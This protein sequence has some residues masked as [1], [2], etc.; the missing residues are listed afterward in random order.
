MVKNYKKLAQKAEKYIKMIIAN[1]MGSPDLL[2]QYIIA[3]ANKSLVSFHAIVVLCKNKLNE[4]SFP[5]LRS[6]IENSINF[7]WILNKNTQ[8]RFSNYF[9]DL[10]KTGFGEKWTEID[11]YSRMSELGFPRTYYDFVVKYTY[12]HSHANAKS[13]FRLQD[14]EREPFSEDAIY[15][16]IAQMLGHILKGLEEI[17]KEYR[18]KRYSHEIWSSVEVNINLK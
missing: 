1:K 5:I 18:E 10:S 8:A 16:V 12:S 13:V 11:F 6:M 15:A 3:A 2:D 4:E 7:R 9:D 14:V 17:Y